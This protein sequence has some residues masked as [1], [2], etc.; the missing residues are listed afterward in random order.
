MENIQFVYIALSVIYAGV[1]AY[2]YLYTTHLH[3]RER[4]QDLKGRPPISKDEGI[5]IATLEK[6]RAG[7]SGTIS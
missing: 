7:R 1:M 6:E 5:A 3:P 2:M 4:C